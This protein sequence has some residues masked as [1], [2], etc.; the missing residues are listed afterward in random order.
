[1]SKN[2]KIA[3]YEPGDDDSRKHFSLRIKATLRQE[4]RFFMSPRQI[5][6]VHLEDNNFQSLAQLLLK[7]GIIDARYKW[8]FDQGH[9]VILGGLAASAECL[10]LIYA[11]EDRAKRKGGY[12]HYL[13]GKE[14]FNQ[15]TTWRH[16]PLN[17][18]FD[19]M[20]NKKTYSLLY[21]GNNELH[22][23]LL[24]KNN[25]VKIGDVLFTTEH[26]E[27]KQIP[28]RKTITP[29]YMVGKKALMISSG[30]IKKIKE[31]QSIL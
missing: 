18:A 7:A 10:W 9:L 5:F 28:S 16:S 17:Y 27:R 31:K 6:V 11:I 14:D 1:M 29:V 25:I 21:D 24:T 15:S 8:L 20:L 3:I 22:R 26:L 13:R 23:W 4:E 30:E 12:V 2:A 19:Y